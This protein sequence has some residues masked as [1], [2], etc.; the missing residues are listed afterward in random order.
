MNERN[1]FSEKK[2]KRDTATARASLNIDSIFRV[3]EK[4]HLHELLHAHG[5]HW[6][7]AYPGERKL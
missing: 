7:R 4:C 2:A 6:S 1:I 3:V 5:P